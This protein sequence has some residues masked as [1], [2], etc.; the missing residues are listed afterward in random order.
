MR[1]GFNLRV[2]RA[3]TAVIAER[4]IAMEWVERTLQ[5]PA[6]D[7]DDPTDHALRRPY[8]AIPENEGRVLRHEG[9]SMK[10]QIDRDAD[11]LYLR[12]D[13]NPIVESEEVA[14]GVILDLDEKKYRGRRRDTEPFKACV[15]ARP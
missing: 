7:L 14:S 8:L 5:S 1:H 9:Q 15:S 12:L 6:L 13:E 2:D 3:C 11:A 10:L 4:G